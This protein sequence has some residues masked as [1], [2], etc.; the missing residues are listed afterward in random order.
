MSFA[1]GELMKKALFVMVM[2]LGMSALGHASTCAPG[3]LTS[4]ISGANAGCT[5]D[6]ATYSGFI[7]TLT[8]AS[9]THPTSDDVSITPTGVGLT[10]QFTNA[11]WSE[12][13]N[14]AV[15]S[16]IQYTVTASSPIFS[17]VHLA[18]TSASCQGGGSV[19]LTENAF[20]GA[21]TGGASLGS[22]VASCTGAGVISNPGD[23]VFAPK[24]QITVTKDLSVNGGTTGSNITASVS[25]FTN[26][27][28]TVPEPSSLLMLGSGLFGLAGIIRRKLTAV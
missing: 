3:S 21:G 10:F 16:N 19:S 7:Y 20:V 6:G 11:F 13:A 12:Q 25:A 17:D 4:Y 24:T 22:L 23:L 9:A 26:N 5:I 27:I 28:S 15:D 8:P 14:Q 18:L 2:M 1:K